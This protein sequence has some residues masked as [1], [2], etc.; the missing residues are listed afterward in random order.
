M[1]TPE[2]AGQSRYYATLVQ[3]LAL[4]ATHEL[5]STLAEAG[6]LLARVL[7]ADKVDVF[8][9][10]PVGDS[11]VAICP[12]IFPMEALQRRTGL[13][14]LRLADGGLAVR[15]FRTGDSFRTGQADRE[16]DARQDV[17]AVL[18]SLSAMLCR[19]DSD[20]VPR[21]VLQAASARSEAFSGEDLGFL[22]AAARWMGLV[23][24]RADLVARIAADAVEE[25]RLRSA[26][27]LRR[28]SHRERE[29]AALVAQGL[30]NERIAERLVLQRGT[31]SNHVQHILR[32]LGFT[33]RV[34]VGVWA[35][36]Q[37]LRMPDAD[38]PGARSA[39]GASGT[40]SGRQRDVLR[41]LAAGVGLDAIASGLGVS[42]D[43][44][45]EHLWAATRALGAENKLH[46]LILALRAGLIGPLPD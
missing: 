1:P 41:L 37:G 32:K 43:E 36:Q 14:R 2:H 26:E 31:A 4:D 11:L 16:P 30:T 23:M 40:L 39:S 5:R 9:Y 19:I 15:C 28:L 10:E 7:G 8:L 17:V 27:E 35:V 44:V 13:D 18:A 45:V 29:V 42:R 20:S 22:G 34:Q 46:A 38:P 21:G 3:L 33:S 12:P 24:T 25:G 6:T